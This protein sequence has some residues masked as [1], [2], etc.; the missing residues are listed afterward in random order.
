M[1]CTRNMMLI[2]EHLWENLYTVFHM[3][4]VHF[5]HNTEKKNIGVERILTEKWVSLFA[6]N[7]KETLHVEL[8]MTF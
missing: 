8:N 1:F 3:I 5:D 4:T 6:N 2:L 7:Y